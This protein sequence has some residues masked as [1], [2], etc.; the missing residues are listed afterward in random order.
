L[1]TVDRLN[2]S[3]LATSARV[4]APST[5]N[6]VS[7]RLSL[8]FLTNE[9]FAIASIMAQSGNSRKNTASA[10]AG[11]RLGR[12]WCLPGMK[13]RSLG[14]FIPDAVPAGESGADGQERTHSRSGTSWVLTAIKSFKY[15]L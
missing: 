14:A 3:R 2:L 11:R 7:I 13:S 10:G 15:I 5:R 12:A 6:K 1:V 8:R 4:K 9:W